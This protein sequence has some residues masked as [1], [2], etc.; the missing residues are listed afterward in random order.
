[1]NAPTLPRGTL[2]GLA[3]HF[4]GVLPSR[5]KHTACAGSRSS[6]GRRLFGSLLTGTFVSSFRATL[7][8]RHHDQFQLI[9]RP[10][11]RSLLWFLGA[12]VALMILVALIVWSLQ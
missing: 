5:R 4:R 2:P 6:R 10:I 9:W 3:R 7:G 12:P 8:G 1:M 11:M